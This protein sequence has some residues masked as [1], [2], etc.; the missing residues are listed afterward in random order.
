MAEI[1]TTAPT[2]P[3]AFT[4]RALVELRKLLQTAATTDKPLLRVGVSGG[5]CSGMSYVLEYDATDENDKHF[6]LGGVPMIMDNRHE[7]YLHGMTID[8]EDGLN[9]RGFVFQ[10]P[11]ATSTCGCGTSFSA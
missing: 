8:F 2:A 11:N 5:G 3:V 7:L 4:E 9:S 10:N 6:E 1:T